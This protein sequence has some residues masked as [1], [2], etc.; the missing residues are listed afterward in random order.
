MGTE[1][2]N[3]KNSIKAKKWRIIFHK[4]SLKKNFDVTKQ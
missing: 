2:Q 4:D 3:N 1:H